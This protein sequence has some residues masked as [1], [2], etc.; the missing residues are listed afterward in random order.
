VSFAKHASILAVFSGL[1]CTTHIESPDI[2]YGRSR[3]LSASYASLAAVAT[4]DTTVYSVDVG[5]IIRS[6]RK[7]GCDRKPTILGVVPGEGDP[8]GDATG[9]LAISAGKLVYRNATQIVTCPTA[10]CPAGPAVLA[11]TRGAGVLVA[12]DT[13]V[14]WSDPSMN[15]G[16][17]LRCPTSGCSG[18]PEQPLR[19]ANEIPA[20]FAVHGGRIYFFVEVLDSN[21]GKTGKQG[22]LV[23]CPTTGP[24]TAA[25]LRTHRQAPSSDIERVVGADDDGVYIASRTAV[26]RCG[27]PSCVWAVA[28]GN[29]SVEPLRQIVLA[30]RT[31]FVPLSNAPFYGECARAGCA[32]IESKSPDPRLEAGPLRSTFAVD[33]DA[34]Y[35]EA[36]TVFGEPG[37]MLLSTP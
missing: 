11:A 12:D 23:S 2:D 15:G 32:Q 13:H 22:P 14:Y 20:G 26:A 37:S 16:A 3:L 36:S 19:A 6:C 27:L 10:G 7:T 28:L 4:D 35:W 17:M 21:G 29:G 25:A 33:S 5:G 34:I 30:K 8:L 24:C 18:S 31:I 1:A 9:S